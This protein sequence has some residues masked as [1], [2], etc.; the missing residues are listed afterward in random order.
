MIGIRHFILLLII[1]SAAQPDGP[2]AATIAEGETVIPFSNTPD[3]EIKAPELRSDN[4]KNRSVAYFAGGCFWGIEH[5]FG[6]VPGVIAT[7]SGY[8]NGG[9]EDPTYREVCSDRTGHAESVKV[10]FDPTRIGYGQLVRF[11]FKLHDPTQLNRQ[12]PDIGSQYRSAIFTVSNE[13]KRIAEHVLGELQGSPPYAR[14]EIVTE[15]EP[16]RKF[17][18]AE[19][20][21]QNYIERTQRACHVNIEAALAAIGIID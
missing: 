2:T 19:E 8:Q 5:A 11:F 12:G 9:V 20:Y 4:G 7:E 3:T 14:R 1:C 21:H 10:V 18:S 15:I 17:W 16:A 13:Q 6:R